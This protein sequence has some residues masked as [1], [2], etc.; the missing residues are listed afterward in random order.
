L[1][2]GS[3]SG[4]AALRLSATGIDTLAGGQGRFAAWRLLLLQPA[5]GPQV[6]AVG[7]D[8]AVRLWPAGT[9]RWPYLLLTLSGMEDPGQAMR[10]NASGIGAAVA[11]RNGSRWMLVDTLPADSAP[12]QDLAPLALGLAGAAAADFVSIDWSDGVFQSE[13]ALPPGTV[14]HITET[15]RQLSSCPLLFAWDGQRYRFVSDLLGVGGIGYAIGAGEYA[16]PRPWEN[17]LF[18]AGLLQPRDGVYEIKIGEPMEEVAYL[19]AVRLIAYD[20]PAGWQMVLDERMGIND[21]QP[22]GQPRFFRRELLPVRVVDA[23]GAEV[24]ALLREV[25]ARAPAIGPLDLRFV[26]RLATEQLL[27]LS[28]DQPLDDGPGE[29]LLVIDG[30]VEYPY[31]QTQFA[32][33]QAGASFDAPTLEARGGDG[34][35]RQ[36]LPEFGYPA[37][38]PRRMSVP[39]SGLPAGTRELRLRTNMEVYWDRIAVVWSEGPP[40]L[41]RQ[42]AALVGAELAQIGFPR[43]STAAQRYPDYDYDRRSP[44][45]DVKYQRGWYTRPGAVEELVSHHDDAVA[46]IGPGDEVHLRFKPPARALADG[47]IRYWVLEAYGWAKDRDLFTRDGETVAPLPSSGKPRGPV[48]ELHV[49]YNTRFQDGR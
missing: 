29:P 48:D 38:M 16:E 39:L 11:V 14:H 25:D 22:T 12:G 45:W 44:F 20:L 24:T 8:G 23:S 10:S 3:G 5:K 36:L 18:P 34:V 46:L 21:P 33:W 28:F 15:Q 17:F 7:S 30:W 26:G 9:G 37:G 41:R 49:R 43:R 42:S 19:D 2:A 6:L 13:L 31:S 32:A 47:W 35:W 27:T 40:V 1:I 4:W